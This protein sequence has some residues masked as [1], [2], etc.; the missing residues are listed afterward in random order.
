MSRLK[1]ACFA[2]LVSMFACPV[3]FAQGRSP[4]ITVTE[5]QVR[6]SY[7]N[8]QRVGQQVQIDLLNGQSVPVAQTFTDS[9][10]QAVFHITGGGVYRARA[11]GADIEQSVSDAVDIDPGDRMALIWMHVK[12]KAG[13]ATSANTSSSGD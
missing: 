6:V 2:L 7:S 1:S 9:E 10:G 4:S 12:Q 3:A 8:E 13:A 5:I 11:S